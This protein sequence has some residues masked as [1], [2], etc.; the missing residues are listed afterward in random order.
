VTYRLGTR[1]GAILVALAVAPWVASCGEDP[2]GSYC[3][4]VKSHRDQLSEIEQGGTSSTLDALPILRDLRDR[5]PDDVRADWNRMVAAF[6]RLHD[7]LHAAGVDPATYDPKHPPA[8]LTADDRAAIDA[9]VA[10]VTSAETAQ[11]W[12]SVQQEARDVCHTP[13]T[14]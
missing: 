10:G 3:D 4:A 8:G 11:A 12:L 7:A 6:D 13:L 9:A 14:L 1:L 2:V 5:S